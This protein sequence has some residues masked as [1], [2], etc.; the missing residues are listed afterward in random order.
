M[1]ELDDYFANKQQQINDFL[2][3]AN[4]YL[5]DN[6]LF[7]AGHFITGKLYHPDILFIGIN[8]G[9]RYWQDLTARQNNTKLVN[10]KSLPCKFIEDAAHGNRFAR[11]VIDVACLGDAA[12]LERCAETSLLSYF[13]SPTESVV[14]AQLKKLPKAMQLEHQE[15]MQLP[16]A[17]IAPKHIVCIGWRTFDEFI[18]R[19]QI[20]R[21]S[22]S[23]MPSRQLP[24]RVTKD[25]SS[26][27][28]MDFYVKT[29]VNGIP[30]HGVRHFSTP[31][32]HEML[33]EL[34][35][36]FSDI[37]AQIE[38]PNIEPSA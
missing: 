18:K 38:Q 7:F 15:L 2:T 31:L 35:Q 12:K 20:P 22:R 34:K 24:I 33:S 10:F 6:P 25:S 9:H 28:L 37:W 27:K 26:S 36:I 17:Q 21:K 5:D 32:S 13:A 14:K 30:V 23:D 29:E 1:T 8:P 4:P 3:R 16:L 19:Y 11:R